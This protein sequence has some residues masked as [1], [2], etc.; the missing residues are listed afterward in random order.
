MTYWEMEIPPVLS[1]ISTEKRSRF[2]LVFFSLFWSLCDT[3][4]VAGPSLAT[5]DIADGHVTG[6]PQNR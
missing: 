1:L 4:G 3:P 5:K 2:C 6:Q